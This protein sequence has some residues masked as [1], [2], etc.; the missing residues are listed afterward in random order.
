MGCQIINP[1]GQCWVVPVNC[2]ST[3]SVKYRPCSNPTGTCMGKCAAIKNGNTF[4]EDFT[5]P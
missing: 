4:Y 3:S 1:E 2:P 5:C